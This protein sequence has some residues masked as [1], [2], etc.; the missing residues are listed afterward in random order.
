[1]LLQD[2]NIISTISMAYESGMNVPAT[3]F[4]E[5]EAKEA[6]AI[7]SRGPVWVRKPDGVEFSYMIFWTGR[8]FRGGYVSI[9]NNYSGVQRGR[10]DRN[11]ET[12]FCAHIPEIKRCYKKLLPE[13]KGWIVFSF[14]L[15]EGGKIYFWGR[16]N[17]EHYVTSIESI[18]GE[19]FDELEDIFVE[20]RKLQKP[21]GFVASAMIYD[22]NFS[23]LKIETALPA[24]SIT[25]AWKNFYES[26]NDLDK[27]YNFTSGLDGYM[28]KAYAIMQSHNKIY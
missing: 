12:L 16:D 23:P 3:Y 14:I 27:T 17:I 2:D 4:N 5:E 7:K 8:K 28:R 10:F 26:M 1:M 9:N 19:F 18:T 13:K 25:K 21:V 11:G 6:G 22:Q 24:E 20:E 15:T